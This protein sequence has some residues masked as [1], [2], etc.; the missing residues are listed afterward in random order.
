MI[1]STESTA[2]TLGDI[3]RKAVQ[4]RSPVLPRHTPS[5]DGGE[6]GIVAA[7]SAG[8][9]DHSQQMAAVLRLRHEIENAVDLGGIDE[10]HGATLEQI[11]H[12]LMAHPILQTPEGGRRQQVNHEGVGLGIRR[13]FPLFVGALPAR[14]LAVE[15]GPTAGL[16]FERLPAP[17]ATRPF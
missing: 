10:G 16:R 4:Q 15:R 8:A 12:V 13:P 3:E 7:I 6:R 1:N 14:G 17:L 11:D 2:D 9:L 5:G